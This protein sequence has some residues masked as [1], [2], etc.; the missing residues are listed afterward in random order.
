M[1][2]QTPPTLHR[3]L[4]TPSPP[5]LPPNAPT[6][7][8]PKEIRTAYSTKIFI[9]QPK[10][11][12]N[13]SVTVVCPNCSEP[14]TGRFSRSD[15]IKHCGSTCYHNLLIP[16]TSST[17]RVKCPVKDCSKQVP[18]TSWTSN[19]ADHL[20]THVPEREAAYVCSVDGCR[21]MFVQKKSMLRCERMHCE[22]NLMRKNKDSGG[23]GLE[24]DIGSLCQ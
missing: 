16:P 2:P 3:N 9:P 4:H 15:L 5:P 20:Q 10:S 23:V 21:K 12:A 1:L 6:S 19:M 17:K 13:K 7:S 22:K 11:S 14:F 8:R 24:E 18:W